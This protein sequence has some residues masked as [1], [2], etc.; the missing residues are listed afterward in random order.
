MGELEER[1]S[2]ARQLYECSG[3]LPWPSRGVYFFME[4]GENR[5]E[6]GAGPRIVR[7]GTHALKA[8]ANTTLWNRLRQHKG[9]ARSGYGNHRGSIFRL[10]VGT[11]LIERDGFDYPTWNLYRST[12]PP[13]VRECERPLEVQVSAVIG[14]MPFLWLAIGDPSGPGSMRGYIERN[15]IALLSNHG[16]MPIDPPS[17]SW[18]GY[19][20]DREKMRTS[21]LW[22]TNHVDE[23]YDSSYLD[24]LANLI[25]Q[26]GK[27]N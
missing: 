13:E 7:V 5:N 27:K 25:R 6:S 18:L 22:N 8:G 2:G 17:S 23:P 10:V 9:Q 20:C 21:G 26:E 16:K 1:L 12:A 19:H 4:H 11:A 14:K 24:T 15:T 3:R